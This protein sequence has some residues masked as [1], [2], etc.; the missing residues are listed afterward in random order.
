VG[1][2]LRVVIFGEM[3]EQ[4]L[5]RP[6]HKISLPF[7]GELSTR[8]KTAD[9]LSQE[10]TAKYKMSTV[11]MVQDYQTRQEAV[12]DTLRF[13]RDI[14]VLAFFALQRITDD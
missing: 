5:I 14:L 9:A 12:R 10:L 1:D 4:A 8:G 13:I 11:V 2:K 3:E 7:V 6:D